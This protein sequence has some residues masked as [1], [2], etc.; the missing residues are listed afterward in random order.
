MFHTD[1]K[2]DRRIKEVQNY[3]YRDII[4]M[5]EFAVC[6]DEQGAVNP[7]VPVSHENWDVMKVGDFWSGRD[8]YL[9]MYREVSIPKEWKGRRVV[10]LFDFGKT[11]IG[12]AH[13]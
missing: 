9:W 6:E 11:E 2:L 12:R 8:R 13:V 5:E 10:G 4:P 7:E 3:R 1:K